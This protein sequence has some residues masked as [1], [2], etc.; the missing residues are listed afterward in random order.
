MISS[1]PLKLITNEETTSWSEVS[2][3]N[4]WISI[5]VDEVW[6]LMLTKYF[7]M[8]FEYSEI[9]NKILTSARMASNVSCS[10][11]SQKYYRDIRRHGFS[12]AERSIKLNEL[13]DEM[14]SHCS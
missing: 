8:I 6:E 7:Q 4:K 11:K 1:A 3:N 10:T 2:I 12:L 13:R 5:D 14:V 9:T